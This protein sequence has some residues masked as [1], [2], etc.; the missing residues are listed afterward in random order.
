MT[1]FL[2]LF[3]C[4]LPLASGASGTDFHLKVNS[5]RDNK[6]LIA[7]GNTLGFSVG[8]TLGIK[9]QSGSAGLIGFVRVISIDQTPNRGS[10][11]AELARASEY[12]FV[13]IG[14][15][16]V[17][18]DLSSSVEDYK[19]STELLVREEAPNTSAR[20][21]PLFTQGILIGETAQTLPQNEFL[22]TWYG[23]LH[24]GLF[25]WMSVGTLVP[26]DATNSP[27]LTVKFRFLDTIRNT[28]ATGFTLRKIPEGDRY[29]LNWNLMWDAYSNEKSIS[30]TFAT[31]AIYSI[32]KAEDTTA[33]K[34]GGT[35]TFQ[36][37]YEYITDSWGR[38]L[39]GP[40]YNFE[41]KA[42]GAYLAYAKI[43]DRFNLQATL[44]ST[45]VRN[46][47]WSVQDGYIVYLDAYWR[48]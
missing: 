38:V 10:L 16:L 42:I 15:E 35:S 14:D 7:N 28:V 39:Y 8:Q 3:L 40:N 47:K 43:W 30:H 12:N 29:T 4:L 1:F 26:A 19:G 13:R 22:L 36:T 25:S 46:V 34:S 5:F 2:N 11:V 27:N 21:K 41:T 33:I 37:G 6:T 9:S 48:F 45:N 44:Y 17:I 24:Y 23:L 32:E 20:F 31:L 18:F